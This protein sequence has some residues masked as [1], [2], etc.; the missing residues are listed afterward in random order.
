[1]NDVD[2][3]SLSLV[4]SMFK[5]DLGVSHNLRDSEYKT[6]LEAS[7]N[8][9]ER[10]GVSFDLSKVDDL[11][12]ISDYASWSYRKRQEDIPLSNNIKSRINTRLIQKAAQTEVIGDAKYEK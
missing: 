4:L 1:M 7:K 12:L 8:E 9:L 6:L 5:F 10:K 11:M 2:E 3:Q